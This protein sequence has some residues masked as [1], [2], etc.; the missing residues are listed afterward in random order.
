MNTLKAIYIFLLVVLSLSTSCSLKSL[1][2]AR[3]VDPKDRKYL[4]QESCSQKESPD[5]FC[6]VSVGSS[7]IK[8]RLE[9]GKKKVNVVYVVN[10]YCH[11]FYKN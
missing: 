2:K 11:G 7:D 5:T 9:K 6:L 4:E 3:K 1:T 10:S 8:T